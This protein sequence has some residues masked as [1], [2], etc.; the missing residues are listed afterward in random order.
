MSEETEKKIFLNAAANAFKAF[1]NS[2]PED[3]IASFRQ[4]IEGKPP[5][6]L[7]K[8]DPST[9]AV[10][11]K[12]FPEIES[13]ISSIGEIGRRKEINSTSDLIRATAEKLLS[14][15]EYKT[16]LKENLL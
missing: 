5:L 1:R 11:K 3:Y 13:T 15:N 16:F 14:P 4:Q 12:Y 7:K 9:L 8:I 6:P 2:A 10:V